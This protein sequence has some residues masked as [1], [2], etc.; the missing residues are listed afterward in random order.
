MIMSLQCKKMDKISLKI[1]SNLQQVE[2]TMK[3]LLSIAKGSMTNKSM[4]NIQSMFALIMQ[5][6]FK[7]MIVVN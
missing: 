4:N 6:N 7:I 1:E 2:S 5:R 3:E